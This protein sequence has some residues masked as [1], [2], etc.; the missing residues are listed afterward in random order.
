MLVGDALGHWARVAGGA[1]AVVAPP[2]DLCVSYGDLDRRAWRVARALREAGAGRRDRV[3]VLTY[4]GPGA[5]ELYFGAARAGV[6][7]VPLSTRLAPA[8]IAGILEH[9][10][11]VGA[12]VDQ[13]LAQ[14]VEAELDRLRFAWRFRGEE[15][16]PLEE[17]VRSVS[18]RP[19]DDAPDERDAFFCLYT[20]G[21]T[22]TPKAVVTSH[23]A[24]AASLWAQARGRDCDPGLVYLHVLPLGHAGGTNWLLLVPFVG[25]RLVLLPA[26]EPEAVFRAIEAARVTQMIVVPTMLRM[27]LDAP[28]RERYDLSS[29][30]IIGYGGAFVSEQLRTRAERALGAELRQGYGLSEVAG[31]FV[32]ALVPS[33]L[34]HADPRTAERHR[35]V[36]QPMLGVEARIVDREGAPLSAREHG[37]IVLRGD[38]VMDGYMGIDDDRALR[39]GW[40]R[41]GDV[42][43]QDEDGYLFVVDREKDVIIT[44]GLNVY[45]REVEHVLLEAPG[46]A[47]A[48]VVGVE[49]P[50]WGERVVACVV[51]DGRIDLEQLRA[52]CEERLASFKRPREVHVLG[53]DDVPR[54]ALGKARKAALAGRL[55]S[56]PAA[57]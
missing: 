41:T 48:Y 33:R 4:A 39:D 8:E 56:G 10:G 1:D 6:T 14:P 35:S 53:A 12:V 3:V 46:V 25:G 30:R 28:E 40:L 52:L 38:V 55:T 7:L 16:D 13:R 15:P 57:G 31:S 37:E 44:G 54:S 2:L 24:W 5:V 50:L 9:S 42:G 20:S 29:L 27:L 43:W 47:E 32:G 45:P 21:T 22:G 26:F 19:L 36:G 49:D 34:D 23:R 11:A 18:D 17:V 51:P